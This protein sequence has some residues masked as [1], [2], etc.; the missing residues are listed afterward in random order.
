MIEKAFVDRVEGSDESGAIVV[1]VPSPSE[2][3]KLVGKGVFEA[4]RAFYRNGDT[5]HSLNVLRQLLDASI[6]V[7]RG[8]QRGR[9]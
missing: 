7:C 9:S 1:S 5:G 8:V 6:D 2:K 3:P 4:I